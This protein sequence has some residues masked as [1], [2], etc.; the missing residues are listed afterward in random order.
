MIKQIVNKEILAIIF[1]LLFIIIAKGQ[2]RKI[3]NYDIFVLDKKIGSL[4][5]SKTIKGDSIIYES[6]SKSEFLFFFRK[7]R[8]KTRTRVVYLND[9]LVSSDYSVTK[10]KKAKEK[11]VI[12]YMDNSYTILNNEFIA[13]YKKPIKHS[14]VQLSYVMP[15]NDDEIFEE[16][17]GYFGKVKAN[18]KNTFDLVSEE[19]N[20]FDTYSYN[21]EG[22]LNE[23]IIRS[24]ML[25]IHLILKSNSL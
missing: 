3:L 16:A 10:N 11:L 15:K 1:T 22:I 4:F 24:C 9:I 7:K 12:S 25:P 19:G 6:T 2:N 13:F 8:I 23:C 20:Y 18:N 14:T 5:C 21:D 17:K